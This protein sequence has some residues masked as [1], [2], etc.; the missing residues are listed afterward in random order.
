MLSKLLWVMYFGLVSFMAKGQ[1][2]QNCPLLGEIPEFQTG[3]HNYAIDYLSDIRFPFAIGQCTATQVIEPTMWYKYECNQTAGIWTVT[4]TQY[5]NSNCTGNSTIVM[6]WGMNFNSS[7]PGPYFDCS[8]VNTYVEILISGTNQCMNGVT[9]YGALG[10][11]TNSTDNL[12]QIDFYCNDTQGVAHFFTSE[13]NET[14]SS[15]MQPLPSS[16][17]TLNNTNLNLSTKL[18]I[19]TK[20]NQSLNAT[21]LRL[22][23]TNHPFTTTSLI[24]S[25][26]LTSTYISTMA[27][28]ETQQTCDPTKYCNSWVFF[29]KWM[30]S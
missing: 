27:S 22:T 1:E 26:L 2:T 23:T 30:H 7:F 28:N 6:D 13:M 20:V 4:K 24:A 11:C 19:P 9:V 18:P 5:F 14:Y 21:N 3:H 25:N 29:H 12:S 16:T 17:A 15:T 10:T 8:G